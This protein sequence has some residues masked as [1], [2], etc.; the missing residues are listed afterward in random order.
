MLTTG[1]GAVGLSGTADLPLFHV[2]ARSFFHD[3]FGLADKG[4][5][6]DCDAA[7]AGPENTLVS[8]RAEGQ[9]HGGSSHAELNCEMDPP[10]PDHPGPRDLEPTLRAK[11]ASRPVRGRK[12]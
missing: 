6:G 8:E 1:K 11:S 2:H 7:L 10:V 5:D 4:V 12:R 3:E 9:V